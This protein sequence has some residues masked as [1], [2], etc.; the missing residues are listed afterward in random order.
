MIIAPS[1][2]PDLLGGSEGGCGAPIRLLGPCAGRSFAWFGLWR[3]WLAREVFLRVLACSSLFGP[4]VLLRG[5]GLVGVECI[6][7]PAWVRGLGGPQPCG[8]A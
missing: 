4:A 3:V 7:L 6:P 1:P 8:G 5:R 2:T